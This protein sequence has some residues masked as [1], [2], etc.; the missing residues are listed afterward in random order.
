MRDRK[1]LDPKLTSFDQATRHLARLLRIRRKF[2]RELEL[3]TGVTESAHLGV[4]HQPLSV[5]QYYRQ[6]IQDLN[7]MVEKES[8]LVSTCL[9]EGQ[10]QSSI[11]V[12]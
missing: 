4:T 3:M 2:E 6:T 7:W 9:V 12:S 11:K 10:E 5:V 1:P 8:Y